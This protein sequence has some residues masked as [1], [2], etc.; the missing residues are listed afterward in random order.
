VVTDTS[1]LIGLERIGQLELLPRLFEAVLAPAAVVREF[2]PTPA[3]LSIH[4][5]PDPTLAAALGLV[6][7]PGEAEAIALAA[8]RKCRVILD[9]HQARSAA[10]RVGVDVIGTVGILVHAKRAGLVPEVR[11]LLDALEE[12]GFR[13]DAGLRGRALELSDET[14]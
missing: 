13:L 8:V 7:G 3:W 2:G 5:V 4:P 9:D 1:C 10:A 6:L 14:A 11:P 12:A